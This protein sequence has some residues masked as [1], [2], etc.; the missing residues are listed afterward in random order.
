MMSSG[1][2]QGLKPSSLLDV[3]G[4]TEVVPFPSRS[5]LSFSAVSE[6]VGFPKAFMR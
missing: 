2:P 4:T 5:N 1:P 6:V 3:D